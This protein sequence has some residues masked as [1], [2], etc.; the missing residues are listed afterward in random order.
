MEVRKVKTLEGLINRI[1]DF[2]NLRSNYSA[3]ELLARSGILEEIGIITPREIRVLDEYIINQDTNIEELSLD[4][5]DKEP[6]PKK[7]LQ[8]EEDLINTVN[9]QLHKHN[10]IIPKKDLYDFI[11]VRKSTLSKTNRIMDF[12]V[13]EGMRYLLDRFSIVIEGLRDFLDHES[14]IV[15]N[16]QVRKLGDLGPSKEIQEM[17]F[18]SEEID[19]VKK[20]L[21]YNKG[22]IEVIN[23]IIDQHMTHCIGTAVKYLCRYRFKHSRKNLQIQDLRKAIQ[24]IEFEIE[25]IEGKR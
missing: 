10:Y 18:N 19:T 1:K 13:L 6:E 22:K 8:T 9:S 16:Y 24:Y 4:L 5:F 25:R 20:P 21:H 15:N 11:A 23:F 12:Y 17:R 7:S 14:K 2:R 3:M